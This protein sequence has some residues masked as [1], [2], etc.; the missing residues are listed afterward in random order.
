[1]EQVKTGDST[2]SVVVI[3]AGIIGAAIAYH[4][5]D[6]GCDVA[7]VDAGLPGRGATEHSFA[8]IGRSADSVNPA[9]ALREA[10]QVV[11]N[12][13]SLGVVRSLERS[14]CKWQVC[15][16]PSQSGSVLGRCYGRIAAWSET[17]SG[18]ASTSS[19]KLL[20]TSWRR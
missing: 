17:R 14:G 13:R 11:L 12:S 1:M 5:A 4:L 9:A 19:A 3:G 10:S 2:A 6:R 15:A 7:L 8:W 16:W 18:R 20:Q